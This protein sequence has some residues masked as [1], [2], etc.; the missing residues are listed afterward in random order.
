MR[1]AL[2][3][4]FDLLT[5]Q[6][7]RGTRYGRHASMEATIE[8]SWNLLSDVQQRFFSALSVFRGG[9]GVA[10]V[11]AVCAAFDARAQLEA[12]VSASLVRADASPASGTRFSIL[13]TLREF[14]Q[15]RLGDARGLRVRHRAYFLEIAQRAAAAD[16]VVAE[17]EI[18]NVKHALVTAVEDGDA[19]YGLDLAVALRPY[20]EAH[21][22][23]PDELR[24]LGEA[25]DRCGKGAPS[26]HAGLTLLAQLSLTAGDSERARRYARR[27]LE[28]A[29]DPTAKAAALTMLARIDWERDQRD[30]GIARSLDEALV[31][32]AKA[33]A[34]NVQADA[35][36]VKGTIALK[37]GEDDG[38]FR[39]ADELFA[40]AEALYRK[41]GRPRKAHRVLLSRAGALTGLKRYKEARKLLAE[42]ETYFGELDSVADLIAVANM[43]GFLE[44]AQEH[45][46]EA[47]AAGRRVVDLA[48]ERHAHLWLAMALWNLP[49]PLLALGEVEAAERLTSFAAGFWERSIGPLSPHDVGVVE[50]QRKSTAKKLG[51]QRAKTLWAEGAALSLAEAVQLALTGRD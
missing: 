29:G 46:K 48:W 7:E 17:R 24:L 15:E 38:D 41:I 33:G 51:A 26:L 44:S 6:G 11:E 3:E 16:D 22:T 50:E 47:L 49:Q 21:G 32:A 42:C 27:A 18:P 31:L 4:R 40:R 43:T 10:A 1:D 28:E 2:A 35:L 37:H 39:A 9:F 25:A 8:W 34:E 5:R 19:A 12:L 36:H 13:D 20:W 23:L 14:A 30:K 45:W